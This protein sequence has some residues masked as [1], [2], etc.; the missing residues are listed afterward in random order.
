MK[1]TS[2]VP[3]S[4]DGLLARRG[5][6]VAVTDGS[7]SGSDPLLE[8]LAETATAAGDG[9][10]LVLRVARAALG[11]P[12]HPAW[13]CA[14][15][16]AD[17]GVAVLVHGQA[18][19]HVRVAGGPDVTLSVSSSM[20]PVSRT[21]LGA[22]IR[23]DLAI[24][25]PAMPD[26]RLH[27]GDGVIRGGGL[28]LTLSADVL[29][30]AAAA[31]GP[32]PPAGAHRAPAAPAAPVREAPVA[33]APVPAVPE[34]AAPAAFAGPGPGPVGAGSVA[35][36]R[37]GAMGT[38]RTVAD[39]HPDT[40]GLAMG[41]LLAGV[42]GEAARPAFGA[43]VLDDGTRFVL[44]GDYVLGREP[45]LDGDV[46]AG[47]AKPIRI[48]DP[49][50]TVS[51]LHLRVA[52]VGGQVEVSDLGSANGSVVIMAGEERPLAP[53]QPTV[54]EPGTRIGIG[55]RSVHYLGY[56]GVLP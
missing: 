9:A 13:A 33:A 8:A 41:D 18:V 23:L 37:T 52:L 38:D 16:T 25:E 26:P 3:L 50:G 36:P 44:D 12:G 55:Q 19:A 32:R 1:I 11:R 49:D 43:L 30:T 5:G 14:G 7:A 20:L 53:F 47:R 6:L 4:G 34:L 39:R 31:P 40:I 48:S 28:A 56:Q 45:V 17:G 21:F 10:E 2:C 22:A 46:M 24:G 51:R 54:I 35:A 27:L 29:A 15:V 42:R